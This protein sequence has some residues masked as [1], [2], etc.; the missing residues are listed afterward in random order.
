MNKQIEQDW[1]YAEMGQQSLWNTLNR[2]E[3]KL[4]K[5]LEK[6]QPKNR[7]DKEKK[8]KDTMKSDELTAFNDSF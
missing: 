7:Q 4:D 5:L 2:I 6:E 3:E 1:Y 8:I